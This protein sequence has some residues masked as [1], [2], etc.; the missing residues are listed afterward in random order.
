MN[1]DGKE[2]LVSKFLGQGGMGNVFLIEDKMN[3]SR[4]ALKTLQYYI[5]DDNNHRSLINEWEKARK[6]FHKNTI[7]YYG[8]H[9]GLSEPKTPYL[10]MEYANSGSLE[11]FLKNQ[12]CFLDE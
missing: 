10:L 3:D 9:D 4:F 6:I 8:F 2:Y 1:I 11:Q 5:P 7:R 12:N